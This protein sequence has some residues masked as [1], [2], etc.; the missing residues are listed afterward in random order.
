MYAC[1][2]VCVHV[3]VCANVCMY[4]CVCV[5]TCVCVY[6]WMCACVCVWMCACMCVFV[7]VC[8]C[9]NHTTFL[10][11]YIFQRSKYIF[12]LWTSI[13]KLF[14]HRAPASAAVA[15]SIEM[16][17]DAPKSVPDPFW[18]ITIDLVSP[19]PLLLP[20]TLGV[21]IPLVFWTNLISITRIS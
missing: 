10:S 20:L 13:I 8:V 19:L 15:R 16:H 11:S 21:G 6:V 5:C 18:N 12:V 14:P 9:V 2:C 3:C 7:C 17:C 1:V 4:V